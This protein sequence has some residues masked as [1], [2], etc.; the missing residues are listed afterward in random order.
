MNE[1]QLQYIKVD[2]TNFDIAFNI[3]KQIWPNSP[4]Y[5]TFVDKAKN[6]SESNV[7]YIVFYQNS[8][9]GITGVYTEEIDKESIWLDWFG[10]L[11]AYRGNG[12]G[13][14]ILLDTIEYCKNLNQFKFFRL[15]TTYFEGR[16]AIFLYDNV[17]TFKEEYT[18]EDTD[19]IKHHWLIYTYSFN[20]IHKYW[21][22]QYLGLSEHYQKLSKNIQE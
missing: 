4:D 5:N 17:M 8:P 18:I 13:K 16:P 9:I 7:S 2:L 3:Q 12:F 1:K 21:N 19:T 6:Y 14:K 15:D 10:V 22:N 20:G 11:E